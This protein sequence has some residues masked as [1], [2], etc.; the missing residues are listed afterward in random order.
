LYVTAQRAGRPLYAMMRGEA[1]PVVAWGNR[2][3]LPHIMRQGSGDFP[4][5][6]LQEM[7]KRMEAEGALAASLFT[8]FPHAD[9]SLAG[10]SAVVVTDGD[11][12][13]AEKMR[14]ELLDFAWGEREAFVYKIEPLEES[15]ARAKQ[16]T[17]GP[18][19]LLDHYDNASSGGTQ[20]T[21]TVLKAILDAGLED[22]AAFA[23]CD[24]EAVKQM[25]AAGIGADVT[26][27]LGGKVD[28]PAV[29]QTGE[30][31]T[32]TGRVKALTDG[33][34]QNKGPASR[35]V[36]MDMGLSGVL[37]TGKV[38][39]CVISRQQ[40]PNDTACFTS[41]GIDPEEKT[42]LMLKSRIHYRAGFGKLAKQ[43]IECAG[44]GVCGSDYSQ[45]D[46]K[47]VRRPIYPLDNLN[48]PMT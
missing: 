30:P 19:V 4:N 6:E 48:D 8:G 43:V 9:I 15:I 2:P 14:D 47:N 3:M 27:S 28:M 25:A 45:M 32:V 34:Y 7:T 38:Q 31:I 40:E 11:K 41:L 37:D 23:I 13:L 39:I 36:T 22:V 44:T 35:G 29:N 46:F 20:D 18:V 1:A 12:A 42:F 26:L 17:D 24:P 21:T 5:K 33:I 16:I 10:L